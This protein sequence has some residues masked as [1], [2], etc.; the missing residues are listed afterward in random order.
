M[1]QLRTAIAASVIAIGFSTA[2]GASQLHDSKH[3]S[4]YAGK[5]ARA[6]STLSD[7]DIAQLTAGHGWGLALPAELNSYPGPR[8]IL[9]LADE[10]SLSDEQR[11]SI[12]DIFN[13]MN[14]D[15][16]KTGMDFIAAER[17][18]DAAFQSGAIDGARLRELVANAEEK[19]ARLRVVHLEAHLKATPL[20][21]KHQRHLYDRLRGYDRSKTGHEHHKH[22]H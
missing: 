13:D 22:Q 4:P 8:H 6:L 2:I 12:E 21:N 5:E 17:A 3:V 7:N 20:L 1:M 9:D 19:R 18:I 14:A 11:R 15:A 16:R 10:L